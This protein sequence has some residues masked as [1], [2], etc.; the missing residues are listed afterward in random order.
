MR[1]TSAS[2]RRGMFGEGDQPPSRRGRRDE[3]ELGPRSAARWFLWKP[4]ST[5]SRNRRSVHRRERGRIL[6][7]GVNPKTSLLISAA[8]AAR[9]FNLLGGAQSFSRFD[10]TLERAFGWRSAG[11]T[12]AGFE[13]RCWI[14]SAHPLEG[15]A[16]IRARVA[17]R[18]SRS[19]QASWKN[20]QAFGESVITLCTLHKPSARIVHS[21]LAS[22]ATASEV[23]T[24][25]LTAVWFGDIRMFWLKIRV[26]ARD[27]SSRWLLANLGTAAAL[28]SVRRSPKGADEDND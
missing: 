28:V 20:A 26:S 25:G 3:K 22:Q 4:K 27:T 8:S 2:L 9:R 14:T 21:S 17:T 6:S 5:C 16:A 13:V 11:G 10:R 15:T 1:P 19:S 23:S 7:A 18:E 24:H 12:G